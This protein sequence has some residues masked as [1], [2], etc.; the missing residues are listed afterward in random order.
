[1]SALD[2]TQVTVRGGVHIVQY[3]QARHWLCRVQ[4][5]K[6]FLPFQRLDKLS[7]PFKPSG[8]LES[9]SGHHEA[10]LIIMTS[11]AH[12]VPT[13]PSGFRSSDYLNPPQDI[14]EKS[15]RGTQS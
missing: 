13:W 5:S 4:L 2:G 14:H 11:Q 8:S 1:M 9:K 3:A 10:S 7:A 6:K 15:R 12:G